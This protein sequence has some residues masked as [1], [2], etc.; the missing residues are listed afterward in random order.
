M[1]VEIP[2]GVPAT[3]GEAFAHINAVDA[4][5]IDELKVMV[6]LEAPT[7]PGCLVQVRLLGVLT[8]RQTEKGKTIRNDRLLGVPE[9][10]VNK[11]AA[12]NAEK[13]FVPSSARAAVAIASISSGRWYQPT[14]PASSAGRAARGRSTYV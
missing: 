11:P 9:T 2:A 12:R 6:L 13:S 8:G 10:P 1:P 4:P 7:F 14:R 5:S 3:L